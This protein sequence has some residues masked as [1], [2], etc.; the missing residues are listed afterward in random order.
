MLGAAGTPPR[1]AGGN[2]AAAALREAGRAREGLR[3]AE[4]RAGRAEERA[5]LLEGE[6]AA[7]RGEAAEL[8]W[9]GA[10][11]E[12]E[13]SAVKE[14]ARAAR[15]RGRA[16]LAGLQDS[17]A[18]VEG[19]VA[20]RATE[21]YRQVTG[22]HAQLQ[23]LQ[24]TVVGE[25][26]GPG[27]AMGSG[28][29]A[30]SLSA[31][32]F[33]G[34]Q[35]RF[36]EIMKALAELLSTLAGTEGGCLLEQQLERAP[37]GTASPPRGEGGGDA[38]AS[39]AR[40][41]VGIIWKDMMGAEVEELRGELKRTRAE[42]REL[43]QALQSLAQQGRG[44]GAAGAT[45]AGSPQ[46]PGQDPEGSPKIEEYRAA[47]TRTQAQVAALHERL[48]QSAQERAAL[49][50]ALHARAETE[51]FSSCKSEVLR[52]G[53]SRQLRLAKEELEQAQEELS[54]LRAVFKGR[55]EAERLR[56]DDLQNSHEKAVRLLH[57]RCAGL[58]D[59]LAQAREAGSAPP[60]GPG[61]SLIKEDRASSTC[62]EEGGFEDPA[63]AQLREDL[64]TRS[65][66][67]AAAREKIASLGA[68]IEA[69]E[70]A[71]E[72][73]RQVNKANLGTLRNKLAEADADRFAAGQDASEKNRLET[74]ALR[75]QVAELKDRLT[76]SEANSRGLRAEAESLRNLVATLQS[77]VLE[78]TAATRD[79][80]HEK[81]LGL[82]EEISALRAAQLESGKAEGKIVELEEALQGMQS[83]EAK[84]R[85]ELK[86]A[87]RELKGLHEKMRVL[88]RSRSL[89]AEKAAQAS[90]SGREEE[91]LR[92]AN[93]VLQQDL[94]A[95]SDQQLQTGAR[96][97]EDE[98]EERNTRARL[99]ALLQ[100]ECE[101]VPL[102]TQQESVKNHACCGEAIALK[103]EALSLVK[104]R[105][106]A[107]GKKKELLAGAVVKLQEL[108]RFQRE[109]TVRLE[110]AEKKQSEQRVSLESAEE[111]IEA[112]Q[113]EREDLLLRN[114]A[115]DAAFEQK[116]AEVVALQERL[117]AK[118]EEIRRAVSLAACGECPPAAPVSVVLEAQ[119][120]VD[121]ALA[122]LGTALCPPSGEGVGEP[123]GSRSLLSEDRQSLL[124]LEDPASEYGDVL[125]QLSRMGLHLGPGGALGAL[126]GHLGD[127]EPPLPGGRRE[128]RAE[129]DALDNEIALVQARGGFLFP[130]G[131]AGLTP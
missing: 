113:E 127:L 59:R 9:S 19:L 85:R 31:A 100:K 111:E 69:K 22:I 112:L 119:G 21:G 87:R 45:E 73:E 91:P 48:E 49:K 75:S 29:P 71:L 120:A 1:P 46:T 16:S 36:G 43:A 109:A 99:E 89:S 83:E 11:L 56:A 124:L 15:A 44:G 131:D 65:R 7:A 6:L 74:D 76:K 24:G 126:P 20:R 3:R 35:R 34:V 52:R 62:A 81:L 101:E 123:E 66:D 23:E 70:A 40:G 10:K 13:L 42:N 88:Q 30:S 94:E 122:D 67:L 64:R 117:S 33:P 60:A 108:Q 77:Q 50:E 5:G 38:Q 115:L 95:L 72:E 47:I 4:K 104:S 97:Q 27:A 41:G 96:N 32:A 18:A 58:E 86:E 114:S 14:A 68:V 106:E 37:I 8:R 116:H 129:L 110:R 26:L 63:A 103:E 98:E 125:H 80:S 2:R 128:L 17:L 39:D 93:P 82:E 79:E 28:S 84:A 25:A 121:A 51:L 61:A 102:S 12:R 130:P 90:E 55:I 53:E 57:D 118:N 78:G 107:I 54:T 105:D 92:E